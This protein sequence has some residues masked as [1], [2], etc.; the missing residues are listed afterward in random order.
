MHKLRF[1]EDGSATL[2]ARL[3][4]RDGTGAAS[5]NAWEGNLNLAP[6]YGAPD[7][8]LVLT[9]WDVSVS[10]SVQTYTAT[11]TAA[12][13]LSTLLTGGIYQPPNTPDSKGVN[14]VYDIPATAFPTGAHRYRVLVEATTNARTVGWL[15]G[16]GI[17]RPTT[18][19]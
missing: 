16:E 9:V 15:V 8:S 14:F 10:P 6:D 4:T 18:P 1:N 2:M 19:S 17:A 3:C 11:L 13:V 7:G 12:S 5:P